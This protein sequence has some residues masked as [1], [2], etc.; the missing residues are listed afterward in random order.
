MVG[1]AQDDLRAERVQL[2]GVDALDG[3]LR[4]DGHEDGRAHLAVCG[5]E[6]AGAGGAVGCGHGEGHVISIASPKE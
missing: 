2:V 6:H 1:V 5:R 3:A 4:P